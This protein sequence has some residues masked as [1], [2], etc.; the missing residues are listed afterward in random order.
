MLDV[1][2][3]FTFGRLCQRYLSCPVLESFEM[4]FYL[5][6]EVLLVSF[7]FV[8]IRVKIVAQ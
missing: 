2:F 7:S 6:D 1:L 4:R 5:F 3:R 8:G